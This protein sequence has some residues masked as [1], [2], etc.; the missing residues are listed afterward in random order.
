[1]AMDA[2]GR[3][4]FDTVRERSARKAAELLG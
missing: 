3:S 2:H 1:V 4:L